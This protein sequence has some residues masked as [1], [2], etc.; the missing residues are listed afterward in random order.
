MKGRTRRGTVAARR[1]QLNL[2]RAPLLLKT[3]SAHRVK[4]KDISRKVKHRGRERE[5]WQEE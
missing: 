1:L 3:G 5:G 2:P 4:A